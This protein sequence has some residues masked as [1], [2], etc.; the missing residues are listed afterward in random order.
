MNEIECYDYEIKNAS[1]NGLSA[2]EVKELASRRK[3]YYDTLNAANKK[4]IDGGKYTK[5]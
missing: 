1:S 4:Q 2:A 5:P 3:S